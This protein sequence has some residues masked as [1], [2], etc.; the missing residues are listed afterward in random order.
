MA[1]CK[2]WDC[3]LEKKVDSVEEARRQAMLHM[4]FTPHIMVFGYSD[5]EYK[6]L[7]ADVSQTGLVEGGKQ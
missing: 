5:K 4:S 3:G 7:Q 2:C 1:V 6:E